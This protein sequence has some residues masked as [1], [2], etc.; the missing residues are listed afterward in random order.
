MQPGSRSKWRNSRKSDRPLLPGQ[1]KI[2]KLFG[3]GL[4]GHQK[5][6]LSDSRRR[7]P[8]RD[9]GQLEVVDD[10]IDPGEIGEESAPCNRIRKRV[11]RLLTRT[12]QAFLADDFSPVRSFCLVSRGALW[13]SFAIDIRFSPCHE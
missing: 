10:A 8:L 12:N 4:G 3:R 11:I 9:K 2:T 6:L 13:R 5:L 7:R 1:E